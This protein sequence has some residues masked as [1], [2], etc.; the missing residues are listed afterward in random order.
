MSP[1]IA[2][3]V[4]TH[5]KLAEALIRTSELI[6][7]AQ[8]DIFPIS[9]ADLGSEEIVR[10]IREIVAGRPDGRAIVFVDFFGGSCCVNSQRA[11]EGSPGVRIISG[12]N[13]PML[14]DFATKRRTTGFEEMVDHLIRRGCESIRLISL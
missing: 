5:G 14:L 9:G 8:E 1:P 3:I 12:V 11:A 13:L 4:V 6:V 7:G 2:G 10:R